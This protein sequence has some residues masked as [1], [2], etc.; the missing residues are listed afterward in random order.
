MKKIVFGLLFGTLL[1]SGCSQSK[2][3][4]NTGKTNE[5]DSSAIVVESTTQSSTDSKEVSNGELLEV[6]QWTKD[7]NDETGKVELIAHSNPQADIPLG[8]ASIFI[9]NIKILKYIDYTD[10]YSAGYYDTTNYKDAEGNFYG[11]QVSFKIKNNSEN[12]YGYNG[13]EYAI[14][15]NGQQIDFSSDDL[16]YSMTTTEFFKK[17]ESKEFYRIAFLDPS[18]VD[19]IS[20]VTIKTGNLYDPSSYSTVAESQEATFNISR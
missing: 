15:D 5:K 20:K 7:K 18:K 19:S 10:P 11:L 16:A 6:G 9:S 8:E 17:T 3:V 4:D 13:L 12:D 14:L 1:L 2:A